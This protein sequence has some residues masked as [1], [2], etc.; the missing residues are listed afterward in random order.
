MKNI[1]IAGLATLLTVPGFSQENIQGHEI[2]LEADTAT[3]LKNYGGR[4]NWFFSVMGGG[5]IAMSEN[6]RF[7]SFGKRWGGNVTF[8]AG[9]YFSPAVGARVELGFAN[10]HSSANRELVNAYPEKFGNGV[11]KFNAF[12]AYVDGL[13]NFNNIFAKYKE[14]TR[15]NV[16]GIIGIGLNT[17]FGFSDKVD[18]WQHAIDEVENTGKY[19]IDKDGKT[20]LALHSGLQLGYKLSEAFDINLESTV[21]FADDG[22][23]GTRY[24]KKYDTYINVAAGMTFHFKDQYQARRFKYITMTDQ[25]EINRLNDQINKARADMVPPTP[26]I[27]VEKTVKT[28]RILDMTVSFIIDKYNITDIQKNNVQK[29]AEYM[30]NNPEV[31]L[32]VTGYADVKTAYPAYNLKLSK[33]RAEAV[34]NM[35]VKDFHVDASRLRI[36]YKG[37]TIQP[38]ARKNEWNRV[39]IFVI[40]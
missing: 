32:V 25:D 34:Y 27:K 37:D 13:F 15:L 22:C 39:V 17:S 31:K 16:V 21:H 1:L 18:P 3:A 36:D 23:N 40:E 38:Y 11:Y 19:L 35:L 33:R 5:N 14:S 4:D 12:T 20:G 7:A 8:S 2:T 29:V 26:V 6:I 24:D 9:K 28:Q 10:L 30:A